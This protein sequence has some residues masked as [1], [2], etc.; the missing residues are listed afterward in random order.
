[1]K[2]L[3]LKIGESKALIHGNKIAFV[4]VGHDKDCRNPLEDCD[5]MGVIH[6]FNTRHRNYRNPGDF[7]EE[8]DAVALSYFEHGSCRWS[9]PED[10]RGQPD[11]CWDGVPFAGVWLPDKALLEE[12]DGLTGEERK[13]KMRE[14]AAQACETYTEWC[15]GDCY[16]YTSSVYDLRKDEDGDPI[17]DE[18]A[19]KCD[20]AEDSSCWGFIGTEYMEEV[21]KS[22]VSPE[23]SKLLGCE[24]SV[25]I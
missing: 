13:T 6:S 12:A 3:S 9:L 15:N 22:E 4:L 23:L 5:G 25:T 21:L 19:Y 20:A 24:V 8:K 10:M 11:F 7:A 17:L 2:T 14:W 1:M 16:G 18:E